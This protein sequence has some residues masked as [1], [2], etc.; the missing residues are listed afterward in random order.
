MVEN[1][2]HRENNGTVA[3]PPAGRNSPPV[4]GGRFFFNLIS[5]SLLFELAVFAPVAIAVVVL[6]CA[7]ICVL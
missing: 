6:L 7:F 2:K 5:R 1:G 4:S 3:Q